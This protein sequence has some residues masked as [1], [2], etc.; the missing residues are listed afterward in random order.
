MDVLGTGHSEAVYQ[1]ALCVELALGSFRYD[2]RTPAFSTR[3]EVPVPI[4]YRGLPVGMGR[5]DVLV[6]E[7]RVEWAFPRPVCVVELKAKH[8]LNDGDRRQLQ[9]YLNYFR[10]SGV[11]VD[12]VLL[13]FSPNGEVLCEAVSALPLE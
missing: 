8:K 7:T 3:C 9:I 11:L 4:I 10:D 13:C 1:Q 12:G 5:L 2:T 6:S